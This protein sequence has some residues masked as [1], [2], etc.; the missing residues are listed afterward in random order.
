MKTINNKKG[1]QSFLNI[2]RIEDSKC[3]DKLKH[4]PVDF[5]QPVSMNS[6]WRDVRD[7]RLFFIKNKEMQQEEAE[8]NKWTREK[9]IQEFEEVKNRCMTAIPVLD[10]EGNPTGEYKF[11]HSG[12]TKSLENIGKLMGMY[13]DKIESKNINLNKDIDNLTQE[14]IDKEIELLSKKLG[15]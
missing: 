7:K 14:E 3:V 4:L 8:K 13:I 10:N 15:K 2:E 1:E 5:I 12:A 6:S 9:L 11:E